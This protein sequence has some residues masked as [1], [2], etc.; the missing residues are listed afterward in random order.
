MVPGQACGT[1]ELADEQGLLA[2][3]LD[4]AGGVGQLGEIHKKL[5]IQQTT[6]SSAKNH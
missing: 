1:K 3:T 2:V 5:N 4:N 6:G